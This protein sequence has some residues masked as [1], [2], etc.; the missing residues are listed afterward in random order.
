MH[1][2]RT[3]VD[4]IATNSEDSACAPNVELSATDELARESVVRKPT[5]KHGHQNVP[6]Q[7][8]V[9]LRVQRLRIK[10]SQSNELLLS[11]RLSQSSDGHD[12]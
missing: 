6:N 2:S 5:E 12:C 3:V 11:L 7:H 4:M 9:G 10:K 8:A 1:I